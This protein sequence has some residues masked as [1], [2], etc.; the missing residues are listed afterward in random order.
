MADRVS[1]CQR[2]VALTAPQYTNMMWGSLPKHH[3]S[4]GVS[5]VR[6]TQPRGATTRCL[7]VTDEIA[8]FHY[9]FLDSLSTCNLQPLKG[10]C[11]VSG[12]LL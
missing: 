12:Y 11:T 2:C 7:R 4:S 5:G 10:A 8:G 6:T 3:T 1:K 9:L